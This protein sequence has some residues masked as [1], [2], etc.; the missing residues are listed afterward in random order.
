ML[1]LRGH[2]LTQRELVDDKCLC[3]IFGFRACGFAQNV[4]LYH[5][6]SSRDEIVGSTYALVSRGQRKE[7]KEAKTH[8]YKCGNFMEIHS[9]KIQ[10]QLCAYKDKCASK[11]AAMCI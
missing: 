6:K 10:R 4:S 8:Y 5:F 7:L 11:P 1:L 2:T 3:K 9:V